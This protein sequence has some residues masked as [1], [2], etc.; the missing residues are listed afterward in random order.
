MKYF[1][2]NIF[3]ITILVF[4]FTNADYSN[5]FSSS[6]S[7]KI[8]LPTMIPT[9]TPTTALPLRLIV[10]KL[11]ISTI[12]EPVSVG[13]NNVVEVPDGWD[14]AGWY[15]KEVKPGEFGTAVIVGH[16]DDQFGAPAIFFYLNQLEK[17]D[18]I[19]VVTNDGK[20]QNFTIDQKIIFPYWSSIEDIVVKDKSRNLILV[21]CSGWWNQ[22]LQ[23]YSERLI[24]R[25][26]RTDQ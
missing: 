12:I 21:T 26:V 25:S 15:S 18:K 16:Y 13:E 1:Y 14:K 11:S 20:E 6:T 9:P 3:L 2:L 19:I 23:S 8:A 10:P 17:G 7:T 4:V 5:V 24:I 22:A